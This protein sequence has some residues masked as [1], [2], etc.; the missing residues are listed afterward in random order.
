MLGFIFSLNRERPDLTI[1]YVKD[2]RE[3]SIEG[4]SKTT[5][6]YDRPLTFHHPQY[7]IK[8]PKTLTETVTNGFVTVIFSVINLL[9]LSSSLSP[10]SWHCPRRSQ[11]HHPRRRVSHSSHLISTLRPKDEPVMFVSSSAE[12]TVSLEPEPHCDKE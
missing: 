8:I 10:F 7:F 2:L 3:K 1:F 9:N 5:T 6:L 4:Q 12:S 11:Y